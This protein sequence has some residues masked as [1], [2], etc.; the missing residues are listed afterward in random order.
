MK[1]NKGGNTR[2]NQTTKIHILQ[3]SKTRQPLKNR[4]RR[5][6]LGLELVLGLSSTGRRSKGARSMPKLSKTDSHSNWRDFLMCPL[7]LW[8]CHLGLI[9]DEVESGGV[10]Y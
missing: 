8:N 10:S 4:S 2:T 1:V 9:M 5:E 7:M 6:S 3:H